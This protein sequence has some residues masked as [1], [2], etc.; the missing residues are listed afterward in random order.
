MADMTLEELRTWIAG[1][2]DFDGIHQRAQACVTAAIKQREQDVNDA[3]RLDW[4]EAHP[5]L[6]SIVIDGNATDCYLYGVSGAMGL[7]L[8]EILDAAMA[9]ESGND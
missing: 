3:A 4:L 7:R 5:R 9:K 6:A 8:R 1:S 2:N